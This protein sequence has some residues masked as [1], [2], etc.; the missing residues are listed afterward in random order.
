MV[1]IGTVI[2]VGAAGAVIERAHEPAG[3][4]P[5]SRTVT[6]QMG[7]GWHEHDH[8]MTGGGPMWGGPPQRPPPG[9]DLGH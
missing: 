7:P 5:I 4:A 6:Q 9:G 1:A 3:A 2:A 8:G